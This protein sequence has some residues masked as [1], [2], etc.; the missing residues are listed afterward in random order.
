MEARATDR[1]KGLEKSLAER[2]AKEA[3]DIAA[4]LSELRRSIE[5]QLGDTRLNQME[6]I[7]WSEPEREQ[8]ERNL[9]ALEARVREIPA[10]IERETAAVHA[11]FAHPQVRLFPAAVTF[12]VPAR[13]ARG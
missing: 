8:L 4:V 7:G 1:A 2:E 6:F 12:L 13:L 10:E 5:R 3:G 11:R 9:S